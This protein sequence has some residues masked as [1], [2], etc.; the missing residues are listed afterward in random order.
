MSGFCGWV[1]FG[2]ADNTDKQVIARMAQALDGDGSKDYRFERGEGYA[3]AV[4]SAERCDSLSRSSLNS[5]RRRVWRRRWYMDLGI[6][7]RSF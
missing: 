2:D 4:G 3:I 6:T 5:R 1:N 7:V